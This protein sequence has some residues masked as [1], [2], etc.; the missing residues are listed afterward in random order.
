MQLRTYTRQEVFDL[1]PGEIMAMNEAWRRALKKDYGLW[2]Y[3]LLKRHPRSFDEFLLDQEEMKP[4][5]FQ[6]RWESMTAVERLKA[7]MPDSFVEIKES[8]TYDP[9]SL[10]RE[11]DYFDGTEFSYEENE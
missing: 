2:C 3:E 7:K 11:R 4:L 9:D 1:P 5:H 8:K 6:F 10:H